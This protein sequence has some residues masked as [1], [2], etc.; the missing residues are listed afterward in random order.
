MLHHFLLCVR[1]VLSKVDWS[2]GR[3]LLYTIV[4]I[5]KDDSCSPGLASLLVIVDKMIFFEKLVLSV[6]EMS[7][8]VDDQPN[9]PL[10][11]DRYDEDAIHDNTNNGRGVFEPS[12][13]RRDSY[14]S[15]S[16]ER[17]PVEAAFSLG[18]SKMVGTI[19]LRFVPF[20]FANVVGDEF[21][22]MSYRFNG[23]K[24]VALKRSTY[25]ESGFQSTHA[26]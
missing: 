19:S 24:D 6:F 1:F 25:G 16:A 7:D 10:L 9:D 21:R 14:P 20:Q 3:Q 12:T 23:P 22:A 11:L 15:K 17:D 4:L 2:S 13:L 8:N 5:S 18:S 26:S